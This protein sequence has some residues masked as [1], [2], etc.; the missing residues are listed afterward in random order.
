MNDKRVARQ[1]RN[2][3]E[4]LEREQ[5]VRRLDALEARIDAEKQQRD[6][7]RVQRGMRPITGDN[8]AVLGWVDCNPAGPREEYP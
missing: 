1:L 2:Y 3:R 8:G 6:Q 7:Q 4:H 5:A